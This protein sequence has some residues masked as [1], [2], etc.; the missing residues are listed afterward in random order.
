M[1]LYYYSDW[2]ERMMKEGEFGDHYAMQVAANLLQRDIIIIPTRPESAHYINK[3][4]IICGHTV[5]NPEP[6]YVLW[7]EEFIYG[8][9]HYQSIEPDIRI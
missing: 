3:H 9:G 7:F 5:T 2:I 4:C 1:T 6:S 8:C